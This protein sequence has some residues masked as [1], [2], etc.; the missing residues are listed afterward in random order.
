MTEGVI[1][2]L[3]V[4]QVQEQDHRHP[5]VL[6][7]GEMLGDSIHE[8]ATIREAGEGVV[9]RLKIQFLLQAGEFGQRTFEVAVLECHRDLVGEGLEQ[10]QVVVAEGRALG[11]PISDHE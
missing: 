2:G 3:E 10:A 6:A 8:Q 1:D 9:E 4:V 5:T 11:Q 7:R